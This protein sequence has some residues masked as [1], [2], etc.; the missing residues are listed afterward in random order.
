MNVVCACGLS[1][2]LCCPVISFDR[3]EENVLEI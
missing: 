1:D 2:V 3:G